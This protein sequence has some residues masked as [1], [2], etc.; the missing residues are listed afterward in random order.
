M[1]MEPLGSVF[2]SAYQSAVRQAPQ[3]VQVATAAVTT[4][5]QVDAVQVGVSNQG[6]VGDEAKNNTPKAPPVAP[7][8]GRL[9]DEEA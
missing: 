1:A 2:S 5:G 9:V 3:E 7:H 4:V 8:L 6:T